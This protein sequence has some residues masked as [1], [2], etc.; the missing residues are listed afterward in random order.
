MIK[1]VYLILPTHN[2]LKHIKHF[3]SCLNRQTY[4]NICPIIVDSG[5]TDG[6]LRCF[7]NTTILPVKE[8]VFWAGEL[9]RAY[10]FLERLNPCVGVVLIM[11]VDGV[12]GKDFVKIGVGNVKPKTIVT[13]TAYS[14]GTQ[15]NGGV[16]VDWENLSFT[17]GEEKNIAS[18]R[19]IFLDVM[20]FLGSGGFYPKLLPHYCS[21]Y[22]FTHRLVKRGFKIVAP[23]ELIL[24]VDAKHT[25]IEKPQ[26][27]REL[28]SKKCPNNPWYKTV[29]I[30][31]SCPPKYWFINIL[32]AWRR[33]FL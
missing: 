21:D 22:E 31:M 3:I 1:P 19:G 14:N 27:L 6:G 29:F 26:T 15:I 33:I 2:E 13:A 28:F 4:K 18:T 9:Q 5:S 11:N 16:F 25:G 12:F 24:E 23:P 7:Q 32:R 30:F 10:S 17:L 8:N 20:D